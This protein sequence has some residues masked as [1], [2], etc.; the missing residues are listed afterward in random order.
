[1]APKSAKYWSPDAKGHLAAAHTLGKAAPNLTKPSPVLPKKLA[2][3][4]AAAKL[5]KA[6]VPKVPKLKLAQ[7][8]P[9]PT[10]DVEPL[11]PTPNA[12]P[13]VTPLPIKKA[14]V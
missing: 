2:S 13:A 7:S 6:K 5:A 1:M 11:N 3:F 4:H 14:K 12:Q 8:N 9:S 10:P